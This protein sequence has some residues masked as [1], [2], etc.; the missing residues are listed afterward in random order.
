MKSIS[1]LL[2]LNETQL[3]Y[4]M[5]SVTKDSP[6]ILKENDN[7]KNLRIDEIVEE[8]GWYVDKNFVTA[9]VFKESDECNGIQIWPSNGWQNI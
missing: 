6:I 3:C 7:N 4:F 9:W 8:E 1:Y 5:N 2:K